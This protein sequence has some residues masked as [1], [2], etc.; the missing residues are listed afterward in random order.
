MLDMD[1]QS[2]GSS[3][4]PYSPVSLV[5]L[6]VCRS[7]ASNTR[8]TSPQPLFPEFHGLTGYELQSTSAE[9][10]SRQLNATVAWRRRNIQRSS[11]ATDNSR[12][13]AKT[14]KANK[15]SESCEGRLG[16]FSLRHDGNPQNMFRSLVL[17][18]WRPQN[19]TQG[20]YMTMKIMIRI[21]TT[22]AK[23]GKASERQIIRRAIGVVADLV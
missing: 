23:G 20:G 14:T 3:A 15:K 13:G 11:H 9:G 18:W 17:S 7:G 22:D 10:K 2:E 4:G 6:N 8:L 16:S 19:N 12:A 21:M 1:V 5:L